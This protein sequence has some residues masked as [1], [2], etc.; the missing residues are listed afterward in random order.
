MDLLFEYQN[1]MGFKL[2]NNE[3]V[4]LERNNEKITLL[5]VENWGNPPFPQ[6]G[7]LD[8]ALD[9]TEESSFKILMSHDPTHWNKIVADHPAHIDLTLAGH[10][11]GMQFGVEIPDDAAEKITTVALAIEYINTNL[12]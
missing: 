2:L 1:A 3:H 12:A 6:R 8:K 4:V 9:G 5:G 7:D 11:H 10:T